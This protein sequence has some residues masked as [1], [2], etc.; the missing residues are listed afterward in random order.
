MVGENSES[1]CKNQKHVL[2]IEKGQTV[3]RILQKRKLCDTLSKQ[4]A[5]LQKLLEENQENSET[6]G[7]SDIFSELPSLHSL[8]GYSYMDYL[9]C[10]SFV[11]QQRPLIPKRLYL[12][13]VMLATH[14]DANVD[15]CMT[16][17][18]PYQVHLQLDQSYCLIDHIQ[19]IKMLPER[20]TG[21]HPQ[22]Q[23][24]PSKPEQSVT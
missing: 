23:P 11:D 19:M 12:P 24:E 17:A 1:P 18:P 20:R 9:M 22:Q 5:I 14:L 6:S 7:H 10:D 15:I 16:G 3:D 13:F 21:K 8:E 2:E 4:V